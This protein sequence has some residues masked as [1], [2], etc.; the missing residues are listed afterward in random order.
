[1][2]IVVIHTSLKDEELPE[3]F[4]ETVSKMLADL[5]DYPVEVYYCIVNTAARIWHDGNY[6]PFVYVDVITNNRFNDKT[7]PKYMNP[8][9]QFFRDFMKLPINRS[10]VLEAILGLGRVLSLSY[11]KSFVIVSEALL[12]DIFIFRPNLG[13]KGS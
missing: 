13:H 6:D 7:N 10:G 11:D 1:M 9:M 8:I 4:E 12:L 3:K 5:M 2:V